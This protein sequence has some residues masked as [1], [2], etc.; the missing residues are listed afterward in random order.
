MDRAEEGGMFLG[1]RHRRRMGMRLRP[2]L[3]QDLWVGRGVKEVK[4][5]RASKDREGG[6]GTRVGRIRIGRIRA[7]GKEKEMEMERQ[8]E[9]KGRR[10]TD[11]DDNNSPK[12]K[13][14]MQ[15]ERNPVRLIS[16]G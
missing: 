14:P 2:G 12:T 15:M 6:R 3:G 10:G 16:T 5:K 4:V 1:L 9:K 7:L 11:K 13:I 8:E